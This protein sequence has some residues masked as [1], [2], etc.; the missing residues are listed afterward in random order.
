[1][2]RSRVFPGLKTNVSLKR[3]LLDSAVFRCHSKG[4]STLENSADS[5]YMNSTDSAHIRNSD[6][7]FSVLIA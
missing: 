3:A 4:N 7:F 6:S 1:M 5:A 2:W